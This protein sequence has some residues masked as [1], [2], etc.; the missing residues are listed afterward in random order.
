MRFVEDAEVPDETPVDMDL[1]RKALDLGF[2]RDDP[3]V[4]RIVLQKMRLLLAHR[5]DSEVPGEAELREHHQR[6]AER[7][8]QPARIDATQV[9]LS[10]GG[11]ASREADARRLLER[12]RAGDVPQAEA[13]AAGDPF[14]LGSRLAG[15]SARDLARVY[16]ESFAARAVS[17][18]VGSWEG[19]IESAQGLHLVRVE[20]RED[21]RVAP[22]E[23]VRAT[24]L[25]D[26]RAER[27]EARFDEE[28][29]RLRKCYEV[30]I[31]GVEGVAGSV[32]PG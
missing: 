27:R 10:T 7:W 19:P 25:A 28:M 15:Q 20:R 26:W 8:R 24:V 13:A 6:R 3:V 32:G 22:F 16:G 14:P 29:A 5:A 11:G 17:L 4:R 9:F 18:P 12:L 1:Y 21:E 2:D 30:R 31:D 23:T